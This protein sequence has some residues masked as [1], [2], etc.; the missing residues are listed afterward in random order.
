MLLK[1][2][3]SFRGAVCERLNSQIVEN[4]VQTIPNLLTLNT[5]LR[6]WVKNTPAAT[7]WYSL[8]TQLSAQRHP[9]SIL[10]PNPSAAH[11][12]DPHH[13]CPILPLNLEGATGHSRVLRV[14]AATVGP[15]Y[16]EET[17]TCQYFSRLLRVN[18]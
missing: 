6:F 4:W 7:I 14:G 11:G 3:D 12:N 16:K 1:S 17:M 2:I 15:N 8:E 10:R 13:V 18:K 9:G 5:L